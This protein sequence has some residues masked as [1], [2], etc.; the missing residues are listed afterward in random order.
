VHVRQY[1]E[2]TR[3]VEEIINYRIKVDKEYVTFV[4]N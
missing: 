2:F 1:F 4:L 3:N